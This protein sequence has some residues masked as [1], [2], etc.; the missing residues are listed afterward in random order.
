MRVSLTNHNAVDPVE[1]RLFQL[2]VGDSLALSPDLGFESFTLHFE[3]FTLSP[4]LGAKPFALILKPGIKP[5]R[6]RSG[7]PYENYRRDED[8]YQNA[9]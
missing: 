3:S 1:P 2:Y 4:D 6:D 9:R 8:G 5:I 7:L